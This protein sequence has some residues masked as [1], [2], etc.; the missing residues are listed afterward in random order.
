MVPRY[1][2]GGAREEESYISVRI[3]WFQDSRI[4]YHFQLC[5]G[6]PPLTFCRHWADQSASVSELVML[7]GWKEHSQC[8][9]PTTIPCLLPSA[10]KPVGPTCPQQL[11]ACRVTRSDDNHPQKPDSL[12]G[13]SDPTLSHPQLTRRFCRRWR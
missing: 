7:P 2:A 8:S 13:P 10:K 1:R 3:P 12:W 5:L 11:P 4:P 9:S 6:V